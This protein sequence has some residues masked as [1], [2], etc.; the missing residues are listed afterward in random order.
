MDNLKPHDPYAAFRLPSYR[1]YF[2]G[3][4]LFILGLQMLNAAVGWEMYQR[5]GSALNLGFVGLVQFVPQVLL[6]AVAGHITDTYNRK[7]R[8]RAGKVPA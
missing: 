1:R 6:V 3:N 4:L 2:I 5:T 8:L 7:H